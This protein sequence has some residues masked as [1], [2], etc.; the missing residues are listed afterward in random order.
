MQREANCFPSASRPLR[1]P[2][3]GHKHEPMVVTP[4]GVKLDIHPKLIQLPPA[5]RS[6]SH[7]CAPLETILQSASAGSCFFHFWR[8]WG[9][10]APKEKEW[11]DGRNQGLEAQ[12]GGRVGMPPESPHLRV[13]CT[14]PALQISAPRSLP[15][16]PQS[17]RCQAVPLGLSFP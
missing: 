17:P 13:C 7:Y 10:T 6:R 8:G 2:R 14:P 9:R 11:W 3:S 16:F 15:L 5:A 1:H 4:K 12:Q